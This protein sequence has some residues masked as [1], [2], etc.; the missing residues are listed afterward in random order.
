MLTQTLQID[1]REHV[2]AYRD[3]FVARPYGDN[4]FTAWDRNDFVAGRDRNGYFDCSD[5]AACVRISNG[6]SARASAN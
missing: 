1:Y 2:Q 5:H 3:H 6:L 4:V